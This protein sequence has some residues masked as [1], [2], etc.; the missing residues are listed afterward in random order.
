MHAL[1]WSELRYLLAA[2]QTGS[3]AAAARR[4]RVDPATVGRRLRSLEGALG[5]PLFERTPGSLTLT[6]AGRRALRAAEA[7]DEAALALERTID[8]GRPEVSGVLRITATE[9]LVSRVV[10]PR[11]PELTSRHPGLTV[12]L[13]VSSERLSLSRREADVAVRLSRPAE[14]A[15]AARRAGTMGFALYASRDYLHRQGAPTEATL[16]DHDLL[17]YASPLAAASGPSGWVDELRGGRV[18]LRAN[19][20]FSLLAATSAGLGVGALPCFVADGE[21]GLVRV[22]PEVR[23]REIWL[24]VHGDLRRSARARVALEFL[25]AVLSR[26]S[27]RLSGARAPYGEMKR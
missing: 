8:A 19:T 12:E 17:G 24:A 20:T 7:M 13:C 26:E 15:V 22:L 27:A 21:P 10:A 23:D 4:L 11:L 9:A 1:D 2:E 25:A 14:P 18:V 16:R 5:T 6:G 3:F